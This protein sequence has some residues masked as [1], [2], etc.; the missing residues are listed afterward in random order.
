MRTIVAGGRDFKDAGLLGITLDSFRQSV[1]ST[2]TIISGA[3]RGADSLGED[4]AL[5]CELNLKRFPADW[6]IHGKSAGFIR[7]T[8]MAEYAEALIAFWDGKSRGTQHMIDI[9]LRKGLLVKV[10]RYEGTK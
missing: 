9:A 4:Y 6:D 10:C 1:S 2:V 7:N 8:Q 5:E 3:A